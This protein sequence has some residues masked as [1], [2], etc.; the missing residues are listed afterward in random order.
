M[1]HRRIQGSLLLWLGFATSAACLAGAEQNREPI[2]FQVRQWTT[3]EGLPQNRVSCI[4]QTRDG[5]LWLGTWSGLARFDGLRFTI[6]NRFNTPALQG[7]RGD[8]IN[9]LAE[10]ADGTLWIGTCSGLVGYRD[11]RFFK[12]PTKDRL[13]DDCVWRL[14]SAK[15]GGVWV[16]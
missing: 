8:S 7:E 9:A 5:Y 12:L 3:E 11:R 15:S 13:P 6:F 10:D 1:L 14:L 2:R 16:Q 4:Q